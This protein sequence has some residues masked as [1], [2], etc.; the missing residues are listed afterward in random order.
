MPY[1]YV[2]YTGNGSTT[3]FAI[4]F[5]YI[6][7]EH[8]KVYVNYV[9]TA[10]TYVNDTTVQLATAPA[11]PLRVEVR[12]VTPLGTRLVD[13]TDGSTLVAADLDTSSL[14]S[15]YNEQELDDSLNQTVGI[16]PATNLPS[17]GGQR[18]TNVGNPTSAQD[19]ATKLYVDTVTLAGNVPDGDRGDITVSGAGT[20]WTIDDNAVTSAKIQNGTILDAD[21]NATAGIVASKLSFTQAGASALART[22]DSRLKDVISVKDFGAVGDGTT[23]D[24]TAVQAA[25][26]YALSVGKHVF[27]PAGDYSVTS[28]SITFTQ[29]TSFVIRGEGQYRSIFTKRGAGT[30]PV[31]FFEGA[32]AALGIVYWGIKDLHIKGNGATVSNSIGLRLHHCSRGH[33][34]NLFIQNNYIG[35]QCQGTEQFIIRNTMFRDNGYGTSLV[36]GDASI[37][38][39]NLVTFD[40]CTFVT[41]TK[42][43]ANLVYAAGVVFNDCVFEKCGTTTDTSTG[44]VYVDNDYA[45]QVGFGFLSFRT[46]WWENCYGIALQTE[47]GSNTYT[48]IGLLDCLFT[49]NES[50]LLIQKIRSIE[51]FNV[52]LAT[53]TDTTTINSTVTY[54]NAANSVFY[55]IT[56]NAAVYA[57]INCSTSA[58]VLDFI[59]NGYPT[60]NT[61]RT[62]GTR[63]NL[64]AGNEIART[65]N[66]TSPDGGVGFVHTY[67]DFLRN[68]STVGSITHNSNTGVTAYNT[69]SDRRLKNNIV[70]APA[71]LEKVNAIKI[72][73]FNWKENGYLVRHGIIAQELVALCPDAVKTGNS[74]DTIEDVWGVDMSVLVPIL[75]KAV[76]EL[77]QEVETLKSQLISL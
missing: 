30:S 3:Q 5:P 68:G 4:T 51:C 11:S 42:L 38:I 66:K 48:Q 70:D 6:R 9:D 57:Y 13:Y 72:R 1:S 67:D 49:Q 74:T 61:T 50:G 26:N 75:I 37:N 73:S 32:G 63:L 76:Q 28:L 36:Q 59:V 16:D 14:Q 23:D 44:G 39:C 54:F 20:S 45:S 46:C 29:Y 33:L 62:T 25:L 12:R 34:E 55:T 8:V 71:G 64:G 2:V 69:S 58:G 77:S 41:N 7:K 22:V 56:N 40:K 17:A 18:I 35:L 10:Y 52:T 43:G 21:V 47:T 65:T 24:T 15:L 53:A 60:I 19:A 31:L 27:V